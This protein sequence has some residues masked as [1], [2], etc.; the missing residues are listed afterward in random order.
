MKHSFT[1]IKIFL[2]NYTKSYIIRKK[3]GS[4]IVH[5][6]KFIFLVLFCLLMSSVYTPNLAFSQEFNSNDL[7]EKYVETIESTDIFNE[8]QK[9]IGKLYPAT[10][11][12]VE[13]IQDGKVYFRW[14]GDLVYI[15]EKSV[16][17]VGSDTLTFNPLSAENGASLEKFI[18]F[19]STEVYSDNSFS[20][21]ILTLTPEM[22]YSITN[23]AGEYFSITVGNR[24]GFIRT[25]DVD[26]QHAG[27]V[28]IQQS[29][30]VEIQQTEDI[31]MSSASIEQAETP[32][33]RSFSLQASPSITAA[34]EI[35][36]VSYSAHVQDI[37]WQ[38]PVSDGNMSGTEGQSRRLEGISISVSNIQDLGVRYS[39]H[40][41]DY[42]WLGYVADG[43]VSGTTGQAKR[44]EGIVIELTGSKANNF[45]IVYRVHA[46]NYGWLPWVK[47][48][49]L[50]GTVGE[51]KRLEAI[52]I[53]IV[54]KGATPP[55][56]P[57]KPVNVNPSIAYKTH[58]ENYGWLG[59]VADGV[60]SGTTGES[61][62]L[63]AIEI[64]IKDA[65]YSGNIVYST[66]VEN[67]GW[68][69]D[70]SNGQMSG[71]SGESKR[72]EAI[73]INLTGDIANYYDVYYRVHAQDYGWLGWAKNGMKSGTEGRSKRLEAIEIKLVPK[74]L[75]EAVSV[76]DAFKQART[77][78]LDPGHGG[79]DSG[80][81]AGGIRESDLNLAVARKVQ[82]LLLNRGYGVIMSRTDDTYVGLY[83]RP[84]MANNANADIF[85]SIHTNSTGSE[86]TAA[87]GIE[88]YYYEYDPAYPSKINGAMHNNPDRVLKSIALAGIIQ[89]N[90]VTYTGAGD[91]GAQGDTLAVIRESAMPATLLEIGFINN[92]SERQNLIRDDYQNQLARAI[93][94][95][96]DEFFK[97]Y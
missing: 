42:G 93:A 60:L 74:G 69:N 75:G 40:V 61:K 7:T 62:R 33:A 70:V 56:E 24:E 35:P 83:D 23:N 85:V 41:Q 30:D 57:E 54:E 28:E 58:V 36:S 21:P 16:Q 45:D 25:D 8:E 2:R 59:F 10:Q 94:D 52:E 78:F 96:I 95:G 19:Q 47:N 31:E 73:K 34:V 12:M 72:L 84:Q 14:D 26:I 66:H 13:Y 11:F 86:T 1:L 6:K 46:E 27:D 5:L 9:I 63:E 51:G 50:A 3:E 32:L 89:E 44:L 39:T 91:R 68:L 65:P 71:T 87:N 22:E 37:G 20:T 15:E 79:Y 49:V 4:F 29:E 77:V 90:M 67:Y 76:A 97:I 80:A 88:S 82:S 38:N 64:H 43:Q 53:K 48:G 18:T 55:T 92:A 17:I 81:Y